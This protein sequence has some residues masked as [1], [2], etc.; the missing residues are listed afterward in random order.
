MK[1]AEPNGSVDPAKLQQGGN[2][3]LK[4]SFPQ[5]DFVRSASLM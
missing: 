3:Y 5:I 2:T 4:A 1:K